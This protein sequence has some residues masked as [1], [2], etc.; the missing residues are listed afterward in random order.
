GTRPGSP[1]GKDT[2]AGQSGGSPAKAGKG[3]DEKRK[4]LEPK[5]LEA[6][7]KQLLT[8]E[9]KDAYKAIWT[10]V[11]APAQAIPFLRKRVPP[12]APVKAERLQQLLRDLGSDQ[13]KVAETAFKELGHLHELASLELRQFLREGKPNRPARER[14]EQLVKKLD[15][16]ELSPEG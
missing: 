16:F 2:P 12:R 10:L 8:R 11:E 15:N 6:L 13:E 9:S 1:D 14:A 5:E 4:P 3:G 7:W